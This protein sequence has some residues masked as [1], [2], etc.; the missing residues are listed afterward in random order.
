MP[1][2]VTVTILGMNAH[3]GDFDASFFEHPTFS[4]CE[5][6]NSVDHRRRKKAWG[7]EWADRDVSCQLLQG[8][9]GPVSIS[10][11]FGWKE[12]HPEQMR[13]IFDY[14]EQTHNLTALIAIALD[15]Y[16]ET[17]RIV[18]VAPKQVAEGVG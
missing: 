13:R 1:N 8:D 10:M 9:G 17:S 5:V 15:P 4:F 16:D 14:L 3:E 11:N 12:P 2:W 6:T 7:T 18:K